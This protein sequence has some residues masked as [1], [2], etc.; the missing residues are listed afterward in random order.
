MRPPKVSSQNAKFTVQNPKS[1]F[2]PP[3]KAEYDRSNAWGLATAVDIHDCNPTIIRDALA[4]KRFTK[5][6]CTRLD[7]NMF[8][9]T[10]VVDFVTDPK[11]SGFSLVQL[12]ETSLVSG[13]F[14]NQTNA[15]YLDVFS[16][17][18]YEAQKI[19]EYALSFFQGKSYNAH[20]SLRGCDAFPKAY[21]EKF[22]ER[23][24]VLNSKVDQLS[25][26][27]SLVLASR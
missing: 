20:C 23:N 17:K 5:E 21:L 10:I 25:V 2:A 6:L 27:P 4:I 22:A 13:H 16:C 19:V 15:V 12:I 14:A 3:T 26:K 11:V 9:E 1:S 24:I 8:G 7:V 18:F